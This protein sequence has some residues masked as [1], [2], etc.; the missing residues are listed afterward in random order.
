M[1]GIDR[2]AIFGWFFGHEHRCAAYDDGSTGY[3]ARLIGNGCIP[4]QVQTEKA[5]DPGCTPVAFFNKRETGPGSNRAVSSFAE[6]RFG[7]TELLITYCDED[8]LVWGTE[9]WDAT[10]GRLGGPRF[11][12]YDG[13]TQTAGRA[14][15]AGK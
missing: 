12:E 11:V 14:G 6:L 13:L 3:N 10:K 2:E 1:D 9:L 8:N 5:A 15:G 7:G 4:H